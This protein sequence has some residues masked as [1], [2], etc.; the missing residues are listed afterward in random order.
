MPDSIF[1]SG[2]IKRPVI[3]NE[4]GEEIPDDTRPSERRPGS[5]RSKTVPVRIEVAKSGDL[6]YEFSSR[7]LMV[8]M[9]DGRKISMPTSVLRVWRKDAGQWKIAAHFSNS[10]YQEPAKK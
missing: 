10:H 6:A 2:A 9:K 5:Q 3:G 4:V 8:E 7:E 1:W